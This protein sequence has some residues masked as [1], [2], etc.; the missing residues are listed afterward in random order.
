MTAETAPG[1]S[2]VVR[3][4]FSRHPLSWIDTLP[5]LAGSLAVMLVSGALLFTSEA[6]KL[7]YH[8]AFWVKMISLV[9]SILFTFTAVRKVALAGRDGRSA[10]WCRAAGVISMILWSGVGIGGRWIGFS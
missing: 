7:Y 3:D 10:L 9:L 2:A 4:A 6:T 8:G 5:W 1:S